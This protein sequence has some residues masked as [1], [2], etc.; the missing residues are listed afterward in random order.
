MPMRMEVV[1]FYLQVNILCLGDGE[2]IPLFAP[3]AY[4][5]QNALSGRLSIIYTVVGQS[6][7]Y[8]QDFN[9]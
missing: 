2:K 3:G 4:L 9:V 7:R 1:I 6:V 5:T 8:G